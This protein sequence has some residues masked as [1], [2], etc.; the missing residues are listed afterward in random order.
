M[1]QFVYIWEFDVVPERKVEFLRYYGPDGDWVALFRRSA[2]YIDTMLLDDE[3]QPN[4]FVTVDRWA[5]RESHDAFRSRFA[6]EYDA[7]DRICEAL[8]RREA[9]LGTF[10][11]HAAA[12]PVD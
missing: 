11:R 8:T 10:V 9:N 12:D 2:D 5:S 3:E 4:R 1:S 7:L 6:N